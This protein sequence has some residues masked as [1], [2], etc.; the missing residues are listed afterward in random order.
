MGFLHKN[1]GL[2]IE[3]QV[4]R[5][6]TDLIVQPFCFFPKYLNPVLVLHVPRVMTFKS[7][8]SVVL[9]VVVF[10]ALGTAKSKDQFAP[11]FV[12]GGQWLNGNPVS[13]AQLKGKVVLVNFWTVECSNCSR[14]M[15]TLKNWLKRYQRQGLE[16][17]GIHTP[18]TKWQKPAGLV[19][20]WIK[21]E[22]I[23]WRVM[24][25]NNNATWNAYGANAWPTFYLID[26]QGHLISSEVGELSSLYPSQIQPFEN[27]IK[28]LLAAQK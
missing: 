4:F 1:L 2:N 24:Q 27:Q 9:L 16:I 19:A 6:S 7:V 23:A 18:E 14:S 13:L 5:A 3:S 21:R 25:D 17:I 26:R 11:D 10:V 22:G 12:L 15:P 28:T 8:I 20:K